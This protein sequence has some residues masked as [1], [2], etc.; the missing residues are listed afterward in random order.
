LAFTVCFFDFGIRG[1]WIKEYINISV[2]TVSPLL[3]NNQ[4]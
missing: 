3:I 2:S 1:F 4:F